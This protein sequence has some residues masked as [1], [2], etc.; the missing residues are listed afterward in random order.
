MYIFRFGR[1]FIA[2]VCLL[3]NLPKRNKH[4]QNLNGG[5]SC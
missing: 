3:N 5:L 2:D 1:L 4:T